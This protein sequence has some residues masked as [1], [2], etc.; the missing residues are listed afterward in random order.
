MEKAGSQRWRTETFAHIP[1]LTSSTTDEARFYSPTDLNTTAEFISFIHNLFPGILPAQLQHLSNALYPAPETD[2]SSPYRDSPISPQ[3]T[4]I[5]TALSDS[6]YICSSQ[7]T[8]VRVSIAGVPHVY[9]LRWD[10]ADDADYPPYQGV[11]HTSDT[12]YSWDAPDVQFPEQAH[13]L[14]AY[15][16]SFIATGDPN[17]RRY[18]GA[19]EWPAYEAWAGAGARQLRIGRG[20]VVVEKD[21]IRREACEFWRSIPGQMKH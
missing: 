12:K 8:A 20:R 4:R 2:P 16:A 17:T 6:F 19:P 11:P 13:A 21:D 7:E 9:K 18:E 15:L 1:T 5:S 14:A 10:I 3:Y